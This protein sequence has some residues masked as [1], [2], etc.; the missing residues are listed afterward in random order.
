MKKAR[1]PNDE[2]EASR[3]EAGLGH[4]PAKQGGL[5]FK[6]PKGARATETGPN[7]HCSTHSAGG[8]NLA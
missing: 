8:P 1:N 7:V 6:D 5:R 3:A 2:C 4:D